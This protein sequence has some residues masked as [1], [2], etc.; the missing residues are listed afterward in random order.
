MSSVALSALGAQPCQTADDPTTGCGLGFTRKLQYYRSRLE[1]AK[2][3]VCRRY[4]GWAMKRE[5]VSKKAREIVDRLANAF[6]RV[7]DLLE[8]YLSAAFKL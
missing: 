4:A 8:R 2:M 7:D 5:Y 3:C 1:F 6:Q